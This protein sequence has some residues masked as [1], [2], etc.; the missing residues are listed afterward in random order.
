[1]GLHSSSTVNLNPLLAGLDKFTYYL[2]KFSAKETMSK[3][4]V[5]DLE[6]AKAGFILLDVLPDTLAWLKDTDGKFVHTNKLFFQRFGFTL[7]EQMIGKTDFDLSPK[8]MADEYVKDDFLVLSEGVTTERLELINKYHEPATWFLTSKWPVYNLQHEIIATFGTSRHLNKA[9]I[10]ITPFRELNIPI[11]YIRK[12]FTEAITVV[13]LAEISH[14][15]IS[16]LER[17]FKKHLGKTPRQ[18]ITE[19]RLEHARHLLLETN[20][21]LADIAQ[22]TCFSDHSHF[23]RAYT[24]HFSNSPS[25]DRKSYK[26]T[27]AE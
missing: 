9:E 23:T 24:K 13:E 2:Y 1:M 14:L 16:A 5:T 8:Y 15:S 17:R 12:H 6:H 20:K 11:E 19:V 27:E 21:P 3:I 4:I 10:S 22:A 26:I 7:P 18:Y 25:Q